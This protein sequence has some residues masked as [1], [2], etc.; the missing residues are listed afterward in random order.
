MFRFDVN[1]TDLPFRNDT[2][3]T[4][5]VASM[6]HALLAFVNGQFIGKIP[7]IWSLVNISD[8]INTVLTIE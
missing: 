2:Y 4:L 8:T 3:P 1:Q 6:G 7:F 5:R